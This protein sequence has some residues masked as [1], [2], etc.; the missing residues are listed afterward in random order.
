MNLLFERRL[1]Q[2]Q[3][4]RDNIARS[5]ASDYRDAKK[6]GKDQFALESIRSESNFETDL[7]EFEIDSLMTGEL[8]RLAERYFVAIPPWSEEKWWKEYPSISH[9]KV[10]SAEGVAKLR[11]A[12]RDERK[13]RR[14][15]V[16]S[17]IDAF[18]KIAAIL[19]G[20]GGVTIGIISL[21]QKTPNKAPEPTPTA[22]TSPAAQ[23]PRRP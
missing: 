13:R 21:S 16:I 4:K 22:D 18:A 1:R 14:E 12:I 6:A 19:T 2:L 20:L 8:T 11:D 17:L 5:F 23:E 9:G 10:F 15:S 7:I 3:S